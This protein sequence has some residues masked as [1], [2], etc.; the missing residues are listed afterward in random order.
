MVFRAK[1]AGRGA[2]QSWI[3]EQPIVAPSPEILARQ[4]TIGSSTWQLELWPLGQQILAD[5][6]LDGL[7]LKSGG[8]NPFF[9]GK[10]LMASAGRLGIADSHL[11]LL[12]ETLNES[13]EVRLAMPV[14][15][16]AVGIPPVKTL[17]VASHPFAPLSL[18]MVDTS[19]LA[20]TCERFA[21]LF[22]KA[23]ALAARGLVFEDFP[24]DEASAK[25][26]V[27]ALRR[28]GL[29]VARD[30]TSRRATLLPGDD[31]VAGQSAK[32]RR[33]LTRQHRKLSELGKV[34]LTVA[35]DFWDSL[36]RFEEFLLLET[37]GWKGRKGTSIHIIRKTAAFAR[38]AV[39]GFAENGHASIHTMRV[40][41]QAIASLIVLEADG[42]Y[43][44]WKTAFDEHYRTY[45]PG[46]HLM[47]SASQWMLQQPGFRFADSLAA[48]NGW[49]DRLWTGRQ[50]MET[51]IVS[52]SQKRT[53][54]IRNVLETN[55]QLR[56]VAKGVLRR[57]WNSLFPPQAAPSRE[58][59]AE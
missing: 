9:T 11:L 38:Q 33:E 48:E 7:A 27:E 50:T 58:I 35:T 26:L 28:N 56:R 46:T 53:S 52:N 15:L 21:G 5:G 6:L 47:L 8:L 17:R 25:V 37:R 45:S 39:A 44:P 1:S 34:S 18:P 41:N 16:T 54:T 59:P 29:H 55:H 43:Y 13:R 3:R 40:D 51:L 22:R 2:G 4:E 24:H 10:F 19:D 57:D 49:M 12:V 30:V 14:G 42:R 31:P 23:E 36:V 32:R 20:E